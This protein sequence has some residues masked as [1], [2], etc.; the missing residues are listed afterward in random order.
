[1]ERRTVSL[2]VER[3]KNLTVKEKREVQVG[4]CSTESVGPL[5]YC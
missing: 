3:E 2:S 1:M 5:K 4:G